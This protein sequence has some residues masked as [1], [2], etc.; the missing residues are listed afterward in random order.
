[1]AD[2]QFDPI[3]DIIEDI[4]NGK[5]II[6][7]DDDDR[8]AEGDFICAADA[9]TPEHINFMVTHGRGLVC[10]ALSSRKVAKMGLSMMASTHNSPFPTAFTISVDAVE[11][12]TTGISAG[13]R[14]L[15][16]KLLADEN[17]TAKDFASPGHTFPLR[18]VDGGVLKRAGHTEASVD[19]AELAGRAD[20]AV[21]C[22]IMNDDGTMARL[23]QLIELAKE[24]GL[25]ISSTNDLIS[26]RRKHEIL[27]VREAAP[28]IP[29]KYGSFQAYAYIDKTTGAE[30][31]AM[32][33]GD[34]S[35]DVP[36]NVRV[37][38]ECLTGDVLGSRR[39]DCGEQLDYAMK[40]VAEHGGVVLYL[41]NHEGRGIGLANKMKAYELQEQGFDT[42][43]ANLEL[44]FASDLRCYG[45]GAQILADIGV[46]KMN[47]LT[48]NPEKV[49]GLKG[50]HL[51]VVSRIPIE[52]PRNPENEQYLKV[53]RDRMGHVLSDD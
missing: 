41:R 25:K 14:S 49:S 19:L 42:V 8:E 29:T 3:E 10:T 20:A 21:I 15:T 48:N 52:I 13:D 35:A 53:K 43:D 26:Y 37:H 18:A 38:S 46:C 44:G 33:N 47:L 28:I 1:M 6:M 24:H 4:K 36:I 45:I 34:I 27:V 12:V 17:A 16:S 9:T 2:I 51:E 31:L 5:I 39:C 22:E 23:P 30:H 50:F 40:Y 11:G 7:V 32:V